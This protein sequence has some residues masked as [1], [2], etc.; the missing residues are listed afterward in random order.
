MLRGGAHDFA[1][2]LGFDP[3]NQPGIHKRD[4]AIAEVRAQPAKAQHRRTLLGGRGFVQ[5]AADKEPR[6]LDRG[7]EKDRW[8]DAPD[9]DREAEA[10]QAY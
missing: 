1:A 2:L 8:N 9:R 10:D 3:N 5:V 4:S 7:I 6:Q